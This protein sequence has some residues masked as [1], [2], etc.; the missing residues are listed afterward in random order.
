MYDMILG[1]DALNDLGINLDF[2]NKV[3]VWEDES[4]PIKLHQDIEIYCRD[5]MF[6]EFMSIIESETMKDAT[7]CT[8]RMLDASYEKAD[9]HYI[10][11]EECNHLTAEQQELLYNLL[12]NYESLFDGTLGDFKTTLVSLEV[13]ANEQVTHSKAFPLP[14]IH[15]ETLEK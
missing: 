14:K 10:V 8:K 13:K 15:E 4:Q 5:G 3:I 1:R 11:K 12:R 9:L 2:K 7:S 6:L